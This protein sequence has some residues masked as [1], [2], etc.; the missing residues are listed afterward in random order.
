M[1]GVI[2]N[3]YLFCIFV[4]IYAATT[5]DLVTLGLYNISDPII[6]DYECYGIS[7]T[8]T[9]MKAAAYSFNGGTDKSI[10]SACPNNGLSDSDDCVAVVGTGSNWG[11]RYNRVC[12]VLNAISQGYIKISHNIRVEKCYQYISRN[13]M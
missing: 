10:N 11:Y 5:I 1:F 4:G 8:D 9:E 12:D 7:S 3:L 13:S 2:K 6:N